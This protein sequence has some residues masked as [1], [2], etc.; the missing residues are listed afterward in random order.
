MKP[1]VTSLPL[2]LCILSSPACEPSPPKD[3]QENPYPPHAKT[4]QHQ[5]FQAD[6][7]RPRHP[8][9]GGGSAWIDPTS[10]PPVPLPASSFARFQIRFQTGPLGI[11]EGGSIYFMPEPF[12]GWSAPQDIDPAAPGYV[13]V[14]TSADGVQL[15]TSTL[16]G[17]VQ[18]EVGGRPLAPA[19]EVEIDYGA[20]PALARTD[21]FAE[22]DAHLWIAVDGDGDG[23]RAIVLD[24]PRV[25]IVSGPPA[26]LHL[27][28]TSTAAPGDPVR[29]TLAV[30]DH[31]ANLCTSF[32]GAL[33]LVD[34]PPELNLP[35][36][37]ELGPDQGGRTV[38]EFRASRPGVVRL[39]ARAEA[40]GRE[41]EGTANPLWVTEN[42]PP[43]LWGDLHGHSN[44][45]DGTGVPEDYFRYARDVAGLDVAALTD[46][47][48]F[49][50]RFLDAHPELWAEIENQVRVFHEPGR[51]VTLLGYEWTS[52]L[53]GHRHVLYFQDQGEVLSCLDPAV[54]NPA[55]LWAA[56]E[57]EQALT[58]A[59][60]SA[61]EPVPTDWSFRPDPRFEPVTEIVSVHGNSEA[62]DAPRPVRG[63]IDGNFV[64]DVLESGVRLGFI[65]SGDSHDGHPGL[66]HLSA[67]SGFLPARE[68]GAGAQLGTGGLAAILS[69]ERTREGV[70]RALMERRVYATSGPRILLQV[71][72]EGHGL[73]RTVPLADLPPSPNL[74]L[75][76]IACAPLDRL[77]L[78]QKGQAVLR[79]E[80][81]GELELRGRLPLEGLQKGDHVYVRVV[82]RDGGAA[83]SSPIF[84][85]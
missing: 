68:G 37:V 26:R 46:H 40:S 60:H 69:E 56:L 58:F 16:G 18:I 7:A 53:Y 61:G 64:R 10:T 71:S 22:R 54:E 34:P 57:G 21:R 38:V 81:E 17:L 48:H 36:R 47:D 27:S 76:V 2:L 11:A 77:E 15:S 73:G 39:A 59:H 62:P 29:L 13:E 70:H 72:L 80:L 84:I 24:S 31:Q 49:G 42:P 65:G 20:G 45:S 12:W 19:E 4:A 74:D 33:T 5:E 44:F 3:P 67:S 35:E 30:L 66:P 25:D 55:Q 28:V 23:V 82:Q 6:L 50:V 9:D 43:I 79:Q 83:W 63:G 52:W 14:R 32:H 51:F 78:V 8:S 1:L 41:L 75:L 85:E